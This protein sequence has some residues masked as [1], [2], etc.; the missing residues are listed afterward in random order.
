[1]AKICRYL[2]LALNFHDLLNELLLVL[3]RSVATKR[4]Y[5]AHGE[6]IHADAGCCQHAC[7]SRRRLLAEVFHE[8][9]EFDLARC[10]DL[11]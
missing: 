8:V 10:I 4:R 7:G 9:V 6:T 5:L 2:Q 1:M 11:V 3:Q